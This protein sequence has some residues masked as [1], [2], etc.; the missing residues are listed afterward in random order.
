MA[1]TNGKG[2]VGY[3]IYGD[4]S[5]YKASI[6]DARNYAEKQA[7]SIGKAFKAAF[8]A[9]GAA[10]TSAITL[11]VKYNANIEQYTKTFEGLLQS[12]EKAGQLMKEL[13][14]YAQQTSF[15]IDGLA[16][17][18]KTMLAYGIEDSKIVDT[19][20]MLGDIS[21]GST[22][23]MNRLALALGQMQAKGKVVTED[24]RQMQEVGFNPLEYISRQTG[25]SIAA[26]TERL[27][28]GGVSVNEVASAMKLATSEGEKFYN[29]TSLQADT[30]Q[31][32]WNE[33][34]EKAQEAFGKMTSEV[35]DALRSAMESSIKFIEKIDFK[36]VKQS[37][38]S[39]LTTLK[40]LLPAISAALAVW[41]QFK[42][43]LGI[44]GVL[45]KVTKGVTTLT[46]ALSGGGLLGGVKK[47]ITAFKGLG[48]ALIANPWAL[49]AAGVTA[50]VGGIAAL[51]ATTDRY[52][53]GQRAMIEAS[54]E[55]AEVATE[56]ANAYE[57][58]KNTREE[59]IA[60][61]FSE[62][63][64]AERLNKELSELVDANGRVKE[65]YEGRAEFI[66]GRLNDALG[67]EYA[68]NGNVIQSYRDMQAEIGKL[69]EQKRAN[70]V[71][72]SMEAEYSKAVLNYASARDSFL[73]NQAALQYNLNR[74]QEIGNELQAL[75]IQQRE[76]EEQGYSATSQEMKN[77]LERMG[78]LD[79]EY[80]A[81]H[82]SEA[83]LRTAFDES[84]AT[85]DG[86][87]ASMYYYEEMAAMAA[88]GNADAVVE[89]YNRIAT[90]AETGL[91][92][93]EQS[94]KDYVNTL[95]TE[96][97]KS[98]QWAE[99]VKE[100]VANKIPGYT[101]DGLEK[102]IQ[103][104]EDSRSEFETAGGNATLG[105]GDGMAAN[106]WY[107]ERAARQVAQKALS[108]FKLF[109]W[110]QSPSKLYKKEAVNIPLGIA[111]GI[112][113]TDAPE[114]A[115]KSMSE[116]MAKQFQIEGKL[117][118]QIAMT[119]DVASVIGMPQL[120]NEI[121]LRGDVEMDGFKVGRVV[122][123]NIDDA[124]AFSLRGNI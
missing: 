71:L 92:A 87:T 104:V 97:G 64:Y 123:K 39:F 33:L 41:L 22:E 18:A 98:A 52:N 99:Y 84:K 23:N 62:I 101:E 95:G 58:L 10:V 59:T 6:N 28:D 34:K 43:A 119:H 35:N 89:M 3:R 21:M 81:L 4:N 115:V 106:S 91:S 57:E 72:E 109:N 37:V 67:T 30:L 51:I 79:D 121:V 93:A 63:E 113:D 102:S 111:E 117:S 26:L 124:A 2:G 116:K 20:K 38:E 19:I 14:T 9:A 40:K 69:M 107:V 68:M 31:G 11:G 80:F 110:I 7:E 56:E 13:S 100:Q 85:I 1:L 47:A 77:L 88:E 83:G 17:S 74:Q 45:N 16:S 65:G 73:E 12:E 55:A 114:Q 32:K 103:A 44:Q 90:G 75:G 36:K 96:Y 112:E 94:T 46:Q 78:E 122:L 82:E 118:Q 66:L 29:M 5:D 105:I 25:E 70:I 24:L 60:Q 15:D 61:G 108:S 50:L 8:V 49:A 76:L 86:Y 42:I 48:T 120:H 27:E 54:K 53:E